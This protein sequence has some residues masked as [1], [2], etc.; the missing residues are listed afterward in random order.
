MKKKSGIWNPPLMPV[1]GY[2]LHDRTLVKHQESSTE[3]KPLALYM[4]DSVSFSSP[5]T[6]YGVTPEH[7]PKYGSKAEK[8]KNFY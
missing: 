4:V 8:K 3:D 1:Y 2:F 6:A 7:R 5:S